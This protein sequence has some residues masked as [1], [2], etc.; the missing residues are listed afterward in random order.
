MN[1]LKSLF[2]LEGKVALVTGGYRGLGLS[3]SEA[4]AEA[5]ALVVLNGRS[6]EAVAEAVREFEARGLKADAA[7][8]DVMDEAGL[9]AAVAAVEAKHGAVDI[10]VNNA[11]VQRRSPMLEMPVADFN[12]VLET[13]VTAAFML[14]K[15]VAPGMIRRGGGR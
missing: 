1:A 7:V 4:L 5:G 13:N 9:N 15:A 2:S 12:L 11:G 3:I 8:F 14:G 6:A 10:L